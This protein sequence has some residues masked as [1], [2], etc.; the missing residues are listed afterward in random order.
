MNVHSC[1]AVALSHVSVHADMGVARSCVSMHACTGVAHAWRG[2]VCAGMVWCV[3]VL[4]CVLAQVLADL[5]RHTAL[6]GCRGGTD[7]GTD[8]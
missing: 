5:C 7:L 6:R 4:A 1:M 8:T 3:L 2:V